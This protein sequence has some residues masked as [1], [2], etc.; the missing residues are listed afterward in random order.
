MWWFKITPIYYFIVGY[1][2]NPGMGST[3][4][5]VQVLRGQKSR[6][7]WGSAVSCS[8]GPSNKLMHVGR[9][10]NSGLRTSPLFGHL[11]GAAMSSWRPPLFCHRVL[12]TMWEKSAAALNLLEFSW[13]LT[14]RPSFKE[15]TDYIRPIQDNLLK[16]N[17]LGTTGAGDSRVNKVGLNPDAGDSQLLEYDCRLR[18]LL[19]RRWMGWCSR[20]TKEEFLWQ[21][22]VSG[23]RPG[24]WVWVTHEKS[25]GK[26]NPGISWTFIL[27][28]KQTIWEYKSSSWRNSLK[29]CFLYYLWL[30]ISVKTQ[31]NTELNL[32]NTWMLHAF[33]MH[34]C[35]LLPRVSF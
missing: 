8:S 9:I 11:P 3:G 33:W 4:F 29:P 30:S 18:W 21:E 26:N 12:S 20:V 14:S 17:R 7:Q 2:R 16:C 23:L 34:Q 25:W 1:T 28:L 32:L 15:F 5:S 24:R 10:Q 6:L 27:C 35:F 31:F 22:L 19:W 13:T